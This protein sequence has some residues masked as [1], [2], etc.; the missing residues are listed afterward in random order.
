M[1]RV[2]VGA[3]AALAFV[4]PTAARADVKTWTPSA[5]TPYS[6]YH[7]AR[8]DTSGQNIVRFDATT[9]EMTVVR[10]A[11]G[12]LGSSLGCG[13]A[14][15]FAYFYVDHVVTTGVEK[16]TVKAS[17]A[18]LDGFTWVKV[19]TSIV[20]GD[21][22]LATEKVR[23]PVAGALTI[24]VKPESVPDGEGV[25][26]RPRPGD[27]LR[28]AFGIETVSACPNADGGRAVFDSVSIA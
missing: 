10:A 8:P 17:N 25:T 3:L 4:V 11:A 5:S 7:D 21:G 15:P 28:I 12:S 13:G 19:V 23:G 27:T 22:K 20:G 24:N 2:L 9:G 26:L 14:A 16:V 6:E 18:V 1:K